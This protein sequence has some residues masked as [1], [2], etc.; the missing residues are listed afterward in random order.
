[1]ASPPHARRAALGDARLSI[2]ARS[3]GRGVKVTWA[4]DVEPAELT[5]IFGDAYKGALAAVAAA[6]S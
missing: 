6:F 3:P 4:Y 5:P 2:F 1:M